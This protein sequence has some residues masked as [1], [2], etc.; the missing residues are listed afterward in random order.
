LNFWQRSCGCR[1]CER[2]FEY[3]YEYRPPG[4]TEYEYEE[5]CVGGRGAVGLILGFVADSGAD[6]CHG[7]GVVVQNGVPVG[8]GI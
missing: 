1:R 8:A 4:R 2:Y 6:F 7:A 5:V 3:E